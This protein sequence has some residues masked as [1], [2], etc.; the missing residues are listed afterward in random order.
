MRDSGCAILIASRAKP[1]N[2]N[3]KDSMKAPI[4]VSDIAANTSI[5]TAALA[6]IPITSGWFSRVLKTC[7]TVARLFARSILRGTS[8]EPT[9]NQDRRGHGKQNLGLFLSVPPWCCSM[10]L[11]TRCAPAVR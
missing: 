2:S 4:R 11:E 1:V 7:A 10:R 6:E 8:S 9:L 5:E 3:W